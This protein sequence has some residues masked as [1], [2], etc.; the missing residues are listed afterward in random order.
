MSARPVG[1]PSTAPRPAVV[2]GAALLNL[3]LGSLYAWSVFV[4]PLQRDLGWSASAASSVFAASVVVFC[5]TTVLAGP[6]ADRAAPRRAALVSAACA[7]GGLAASAATTSVWWLLVCY[8]GVFGVGNGLGYVVA[9][10]AA[11]RALPDHGGTGVGVAVAGYALGPLLVAAP[12]GAVIAALGWRHAFLLAGGLLG[13]VMVV[14]AA[15]L[16][17]GPPPPRPSPPPPPP[18]RGASRR[19]RPRATL[20]TRPHGVGL[21]LV[22]ACGA[23]AGLMVVGHA[24]PLLLDRG[25]SATA[26]SA[27]VSL[28][29]AG[30]A[31]GRV[32]AGWAS[33]RIGAPLALTVALAVAAV[34]AIVLAVSGGAV[35][36]ALVT[37]VG[38]AYGAVA[39][40]VPAA[41]ADLF[42]E[43]AFGANF[44]VVFTAWGV[45][46]FFGP[47]VGGWLAE[48]A[49]YTAALQAA[50]AVAALGL[51]AALWLRRAAPRAA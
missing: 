41:T 47:L 45:G 1:T 35:L 12:L 19:T 9:L 50:A 26:A 40:A 33:D 25:L 10:T 48:R 20:L 7:A 46:G 30:N 29:A 43:A 3:C 22:F 6:L 42:G 14:A 34:A 44:G 38:V 2:A 8:A 36:V 17:G 23:F 32:L 11:R 31:S 37:T 16:G 18:P 39:A 5:I 4:E 15:L 27:A 28:L 49:G 24:A 13:A 21:W 51:L